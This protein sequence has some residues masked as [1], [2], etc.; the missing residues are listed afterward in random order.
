MPVARETGREDSAG[1]R[2][3]VAGSNRSA[4][5]TAAFCSRRERST[6]VIGVSV[7]SKKTAGRKNKRFFGLRSRRTS[8][9]AI[10]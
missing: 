10:A 2:G 8:G 3:G 1:N 5:V 7:S 6:V 9:I 4:P